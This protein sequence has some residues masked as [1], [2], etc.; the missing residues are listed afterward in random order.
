MDDGC[1]K[2]PGRM[3]S[4]EKD[5]GSDVRS[6]STSEGERADVQDDGTASHA[7][8]HGSSCSHKSAG[9]EDGGCELGGKL[10]ETRLRWYGHVLRREEEYVGQRS[11]K[12]IVGM[13]GRG[14]AKRRWMDCVRE[15]YR[16]ERGGCHR[17]IEM[18]AED[19]HR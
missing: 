2:D 7:V 5:K 15:V 14:R 12:M 10:R 1:K 19:P 3:G 16:R 8:G 11:R 13:R 4:M 18:E 9:K 6:T 17:K